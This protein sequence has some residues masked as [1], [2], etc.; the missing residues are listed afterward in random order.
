MRPNRLVLLRVRLIIALAMVVL[1]GRIAWPVASAQSGGTAGGYSLLKGAIDMH[2]HVDPDVSE[3][4]AVDTIDIAKLRYARDQGI[5]GVVL[6]NKY[7]TTELLA[8]M[9]R[10]EI[11]DIEIFGGIVLDFNAGGINLAKVEYMAT[12]MR[13]RPGRL[14]WM[15]I[16]DSENEARR[17]KQ[18]N[19]PFV[20]VVHNGE[21][22]PEVKQLIALIAKHQLTLA[23]GH[24]SPEQGLMVLRE[25]H[26][27]GVKHMLVTHPMDAGVFM[28]E[29]QMREAIALGAFLEF[30]FRNIL[31]GKIQLPLGLSPIAG[32]RVEMIRKLGPE[33]VVI[34]EFWS[35]THSR[36]GIGSYKDSYEYGGPDE[37]AAWAK[38]M[39]AQGFTNRDLDLMCKENPAKLLGLPVR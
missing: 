11:P 24:L 33:H 22:V 7:G 37:L 38:A 39:N 26:R 8:Y 16:F 27:Q 32:G 36:G 30:D 12:Q 14:V 19:R 28:T 21:V 20:R 17:S 1:L 31:T 13:G 25:A 34:D 9:L 2:L 4:Q 35:K 23:T 5:R 29:E 3:T 10:K 15:P 18:P 6:K